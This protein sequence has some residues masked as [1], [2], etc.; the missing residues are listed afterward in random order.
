MPH[1]MVELKI[2]ATFIIHIILREP[3]VNKKKPDK[4]RLAAATS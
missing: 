3:G 2:K 4:A 1:C